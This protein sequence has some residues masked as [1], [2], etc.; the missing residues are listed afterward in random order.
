MRFILRTCL[1][2]FLPVT[3]LVRSGATSASAAAVEEPGPA[4][5]NASVPA[6]PPQPF[7]TRKDDSGWWLAAPDGQ[8]FFSLGVCCVNQGT[9]REAW[10]SENPSYAAWQHHDYSIAWAGTNLLRLTSWGFTTVGGWSDFD[11]LRQSPEQKLWLTPVLHIGQTVGAP[12]WDMWDERNVR[13]MENIARERILATRDDPRILGYY[14]D[15]ELGWWN[16]TLW[17]VTLEQ[18]ASSG[19]RRRLIQLLRETYTNDWTKLELDFRPEAADDWRELEQG[20]MLFLKP[21]SQGIHTMRRFLA[22]PQTAITS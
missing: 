12:W 20:G 8:K 22:S 17:K 6:S 13:R 10:D 11:V 5:T 19:Q 21:G 18:P 4:S 7:A 1:A 14:S 16:A 3:L 15:N 2:L 9:S